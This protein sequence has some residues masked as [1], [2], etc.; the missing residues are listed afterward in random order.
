MKLVCEGKYLCINMEDFVPESIDM[1]EVFCEGFEHDK[2][3]E[4]L[5]ALGALD[6]EH[7]LLDFLE[8][9]SLN[10]TRARI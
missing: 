5:D 9:T 2:E 6:G 1:E 7:T 8:D 3:S 4:F 10:G